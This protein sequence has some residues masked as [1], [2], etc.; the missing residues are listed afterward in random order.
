MQKKGGQSEIA[1][2]FFPGRNPQ[3]Y[4]KYP[5]EKFYRAWTHLDTEIGI[6]T[7]ISRHSSLDLGIGFWDHDSIDPHDAHF[8]RKTHLYPPPGIPHD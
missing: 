7:N 3:F 8:T 6:Q 5:G 4:I 1:F 2:L